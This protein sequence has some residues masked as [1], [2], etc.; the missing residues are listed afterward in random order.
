[1]VRLL[2]QL[3]Q[4]ITRIAANVHEGG[5]RAAVLFSVGANAAHGLPRKPE[6]KRQAVRTLVRDIQEGCT[7]DLHICRGRPRDQQCW[8]AWADRAIARECAVSHTMVQGVR[9]EF[10]A[11]LER[12]TNQQLLT[13]AG[14]QSATR[15]YNHPATGQPTAMNTGNIGSITQQ[16]APQPETGSDVEAMPTGYQAD[17][18]DYVPAVQP[19]GVHP[20]TERAIDI[21]IKAQILALSLKITPSPSSRKRSAILVL[22]TSMKPGPSSTRRPASRPR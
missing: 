12:S 2:E 20:A 18:E 6:D 5:Q 1:V 7:V 21:A 17:I 11:E 10:M 13:G 15:T 3:N 4:D 16:P 19:D 9:S 14:C 8:N 22:K